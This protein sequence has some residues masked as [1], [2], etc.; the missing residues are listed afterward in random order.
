VKDILDLNKR[1]WDSI[2]ERYGDRSETP[3]SDVFIT[4]TGRLPEKGKVV[5]L[6]CGTGVP[7]AR[8]LVERGF[9][10]VGVDLSED[11]VKVASENVP[12]ASFVRLSMNEITY[13][14]EFDPWIYRPHQKSL[15]PLPMYAPYRT[16]PINQTIMNNTT[17]NP[18]G[19]IIPFQLRNQYKAMENRSKAPRGNSTAFLLAVTCL[20]YS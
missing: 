10:V 1:A 11:M 14:D 7:Y 20:G 3:I 4:F 9:D 5:D 6:G 2:A 19:L 18:L 16:N 15:S 13:R 8:S 17:A 12:G